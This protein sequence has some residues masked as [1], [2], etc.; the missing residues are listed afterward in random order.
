MNGNDYRDKFRDPKWQRKR[1][2]VMG[3][4]NFLCEYCGE[5][6]KEL[7]IHHPAYRKGAEPWE[8]EDEELMCLCCD[9]HEKVTKGGALLKE[10]ALSSPDNFTSFLMAIADGAVATAACYLMQSLHPIAESGAIKVW[11]ESDSVA[12]LESVHELCKLYSPVWKEAE[13]YRRANNFPPIRASAARR[14]KAGK[15]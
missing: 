6:D 11:P 5:S 7:Q 8:Y 15:K 3:R 9:C 12:V 2:A 14:A 13:F 4:A 1:L 10:I